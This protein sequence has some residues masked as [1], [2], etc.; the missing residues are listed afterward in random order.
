MAKYFNYFPKTLY[1]LSDEKNSADL[2][3]NIIARFGFEKE[4]KENLNIY[5]SYDIQDGDS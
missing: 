5:Y 1:S 2:V 4:L 3:T